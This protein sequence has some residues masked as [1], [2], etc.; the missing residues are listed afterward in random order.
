[1]EVGGDGGLAEYESAMLDK[2]EFLLALERER[3]FGRAAESCGVAQPT[4]SLGL[5]GL[6][7]MLKAPLVKRSSRFKGFTPEGERV[8]VW[9]RRMVGDA[10]AMRQEIFGLQMGVGSHIRIAA[11]PSA[12][13]IVASLTAPFQSRNPS[14]RFT[15]IMRTSEV[16]LDL[17]H[18]REI[19]AG[20]TYLDNEPI[21]D[22]LNVPLY[23]EQYLLLTTPSG[24]CGNADRV[25]WA[26]VATLPLCLFTQELQHRRIVDKAFQAIGADAKP[27]VE[28]DSVVALASHVGTG[29][30]ISIVPH[31]ILGAIDINGALRV[32]PIVEPEVSHTIGL[33]VSERFPVP[34]TIASLMQD[35]RSRVS[36]IASAS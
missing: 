9:A 21:G 28:T 26:Q 15:V 8:L 24:P 14:V 19:D 5:Q 22:V 16:L 1:M 12:M 30:W 25:T 27:M 31:S 20:V 10:H 18:Q 13:P 6:E 34:P 4:L 29:R 7:E 11:I 23:H 36:E 32:V 17:L 2:L 35:A 3:H 33:V